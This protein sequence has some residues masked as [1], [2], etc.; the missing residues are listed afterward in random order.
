ML[1]LFRH[2]PLV[3]CVMCATP[4]AD[5]IFCVLFMLCISGML[6]MHIS[7]ILICITGNRS[8]V[9]VLARWQSMH[10][11]CLMFFFLSCRRAAVVYMAIQHF[12]KYYTH[13][14]IAF[15]TYRQWFL[16]YMRSVWE[17]LERNSHGIETHHITEPFVN[18]LTRTLGLKFCALVS[19][20]QR[21]VLLLFFAMSVKRERAKQYI[22]SWVVR[23]HTGVSVCEDRGS[24][25]TTSMAQ[26]GSE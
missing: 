20:A 12:V 13:Y 10:I 15:A 14:S 6:R 22:W 21:Q 16:D 23:T 25:G 8:E 17:E 11:F 9:E 26:R 7:S 4:T 18:G 1:S 2:V 24:R 5:L 19:P 3:V